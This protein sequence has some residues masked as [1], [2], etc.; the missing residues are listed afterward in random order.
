MIKLVVWARI[1]AHL[2]PQSRTA[3]DRPR[4]AFRVATEKDFAELASKLKK[5]LS[6]QPQSWVTT[7]EGFIVIHVTGAS[8]GNAMAEYPVLI[9]RRKD[10]NEKDIVTDQIV[11]EA[12][13]VILVQTPFMQS[14]ATSAIAPES[15]PIITC[16]R[17]VCNV[18][19]KRN[20][21]E[22]TVQHG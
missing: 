20:H 10:A 5:I 13:P 16:T 11:L 2:R 17:P 9:R 8:K 6:V 15:L 1:A 4:L 22:E 18:P 19:R 7:N 12:L 14:N 21:S 3:K